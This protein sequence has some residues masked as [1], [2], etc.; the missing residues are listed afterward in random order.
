MIEEGFSE[1]MASNFKSPAALMNF[2]AAFLIGP[3]TINETIDSVTVNIVVDLSKYFTSPIQDLRTLLPK[4]KFRTPA[5]RIERYTDV[6]LVERSFS[7]GYFTIYP[8]DKDEFEIRIDAAAIDSI[9]TLFNEYRVYLKSPYQFYAYGDSIIT[10]VGLDLVDDAGN[11]IPYQ[12]IADM[13]DAKTFLPYFNDYT[14]N[15]IFPGMTRPKWLELIY[16]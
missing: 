16:Q 12:N 11:V 13:V 7:P 10:T 6:W 5:E 2:I 14:F 3:Y 9:D 4:Y 1:S 15:G 8:F